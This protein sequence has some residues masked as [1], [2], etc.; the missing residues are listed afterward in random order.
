MIKNLNIV[1]EINNNE[2]QKVSRTQ[3][4]KCCMCLNKLFGLLVENERKQKINK[5]I[6]SP[7][8]CNASFSSSMTFCA[9]VEEF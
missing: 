1:T 7:M 9:N 8:V 2:G 6:C 4:L 3:Q 5:Y